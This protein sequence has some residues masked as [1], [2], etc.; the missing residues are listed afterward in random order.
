M[1]QQVGRERVDVE[2]LGA[3]YLGDV[4]VDL[5][6]RAGRVDGSDSALAR[7]AALADGSPAPYCA[8]HF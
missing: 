4:T 3:L 2:T 8:T 1:G 5:M 7:F 6:A